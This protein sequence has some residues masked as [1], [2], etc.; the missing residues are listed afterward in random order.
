MKQKVK[1]ADLIGKAK[2]RV[3]LVGI[4]LEGGWNTLPPGCPELVR[5]GSIEFGTIE[6]YPPDVRRIYDAIADR[7][8]TTAERLLIEQTRRSLVPQYIGELPSRPMKPSEIEPWLL[9]FHPQ[10]V[11][12][13]CGLHVH[14]SFKNLLHYQWLLTPEFRD[15]MHEGIRNWALAEGIPDTHPLWRRLLGQS[16]Y[17]TS[18]FFGEK[19][20]RIP[21]KNFNR[22]RGVN[23]YTSVNYSYGTHGTIECRLLPMFQEPAQ[24]VSAVK[25]VI[26][27]TNAF[28][29]TAA[30]R[31]EKHLIELAVVEEDLQREEFYEC[32]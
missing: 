15:A 14:M 13:T 30:T 26:N 1:L 2:N 28:L 24:S 6:D 9:K 21:E 31:E 16:N 8:W 12:S 10:R 7:A 18:H 29:L 19:Q 22:G 4:E 32:V 5:D 3:L 11:N 27:I 20:A 25:Q 23:R 17:C